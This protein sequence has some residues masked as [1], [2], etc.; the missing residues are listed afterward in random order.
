VLQPSWS[1]MYVLAR[2]ER[3]TLLE[4]RNVRT[5]IRYWWVWLSTSRFIFAAADSQHRAKLGEEPRGTTR[6]ACSRIYYD[7][8]CIVLA[9]LR[10]ASPHLKGGSQ[11][12]IARIPANLPCGVSCIPAG[13]RH[14]C[15]CQVG[16]QELVTT[17]SRVKNMS[18]NVQESNNK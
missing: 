6:S 10:N 7:G 3:D 11:E 1:T 8:D 9:R 18:F 4:S 15:Q 16:T 13:R 14:N 12:D 17:R 2:T 5:P